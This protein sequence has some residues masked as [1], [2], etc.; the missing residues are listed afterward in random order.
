MKDI[1]K[2]EQKLQ[3]RSKILEAEKAL[4]PLVD[5]K[6]IVKGDTKVFPLEHMFVD[7]VYVRQMSMKKDSAVIGKIHKNEHVWF[8]LSGHLSVASE[9]NVNDYMAPCYVKAAAGSKRVI[10]AY[11]DSVWVNVYP[12]PTNT[13]DL[14]QLEKEIIVKDYEEFEE[15]INNKNNII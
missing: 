10:Y 2:K 11:E 3:V 7:G 9:T 14:K 4:I 15:Y 6:N 1:V 13:E 12:N 8:L 5:G